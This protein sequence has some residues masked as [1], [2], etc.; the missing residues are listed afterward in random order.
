MLWVYDNN[1]GSSVIGKA[2]DR[3]EYTMRIT[4]YIEDKYKVIVISSL[5]LDDDRKTRDFFGH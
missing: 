4:K 2:G 1:F 5:L 3:N